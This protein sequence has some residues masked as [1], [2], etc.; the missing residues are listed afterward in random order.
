MCKRINI[1]LQS[2]EKRFSLEFEGKSM[3]QLLFLQLLLTYIFCLLIT[4]ER[5]IKMLNQS[6]IQEIKS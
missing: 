6:F 5:T 4:F 2:M 3:L 1:Y